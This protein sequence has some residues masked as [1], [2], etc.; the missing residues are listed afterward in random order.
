[1]KSEAKGRERVVAGKSFNKLAWP[2][3][4]EVKLTTGKGDDG[5]GQI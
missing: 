1:M 4:I 2:Y 3:I 5:N